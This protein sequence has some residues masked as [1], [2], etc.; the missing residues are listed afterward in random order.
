MLKS[1]SQRNVLE[2]METFKQGAAQFMKM[3]PQRQQ[4][5]A[6]RMLFCFL[7]DLA[8]DSGVAL[9]VGFYE[10]LQATMDRYLPA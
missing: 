7:C 10:E 2:S 4:R 1:V 9:P 5:M 6:L 8:E 3:H